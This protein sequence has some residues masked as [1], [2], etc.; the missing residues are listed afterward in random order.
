LCARET[1]LF[2]DGDETESA[3]EL[4]IV[5]ALPLSIIAFNSVMRFRVSSVRSR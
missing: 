3:L 5:L 1:S 4:A 2:R